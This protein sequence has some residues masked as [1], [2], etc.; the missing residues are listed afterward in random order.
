MVKS[1][2]DMFVPGSNEVQVGPGAQQRFLDQV[3][4]PVD[5]AAE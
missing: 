4:G 1:H 3:V 5:I 2:A